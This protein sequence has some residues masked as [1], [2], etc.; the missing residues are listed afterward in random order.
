MIKAIM[1]WVSLSKGNHPE[2]INYERLISYNQDELTQA[3]F[4]F[5]FLVPEI[6][7]E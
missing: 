5:V 3:K 1:C 6:L 2:N 4:N 7:K